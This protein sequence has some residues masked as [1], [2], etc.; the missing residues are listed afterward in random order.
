MGPCLTK[1]ESLY[2]E[3]AYK[4][5]QDK[6]DELINVHMLLEGNIWKGILSPAV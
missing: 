2:H 3:T 6:C 4:C 1:P 5:I